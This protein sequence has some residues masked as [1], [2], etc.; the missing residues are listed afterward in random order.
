MYVHI[1]TY[2]LIS[3]SWKYPQDANI[4][5]QFFCNFERL[6]CMRTEYGAVVNCWKKQMIINLPHSG[7]YFSLTY[8]RDHS[9]YQTL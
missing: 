5:V 3:N 2:R 1:H 8:L 9:P 4:F 6:Y 7:F